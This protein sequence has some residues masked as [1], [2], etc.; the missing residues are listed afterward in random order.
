MK[1]SQFRILTKIDNLTHALQSIEPGS[2]R[3]ENDEEKRV[4]SPPSDQFLHDCK[5]FVQRIGAVGRPRYNITE[6]M[7]FCLCADGF[8][9]REIAKILGVNH[10]VVYDRAKEFG[11]K[12]D[13]YG[14]THISDD[15]LDVYVRDLVEKFPYNGR[16]VNCTFLRSE[17]GIKVSQRRTLAAMKRCDPLGYIQRWA[18]RLY[19]RDYDVPGPHYLWHMDTNHKVCFY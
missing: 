11:I 5:A 8:S 7:L 17:F 1:N 3:L 18:N 9:A 13:A 2:I 19:R 15:E 16:H 6:E 12:F 14:L 10:T 4:D